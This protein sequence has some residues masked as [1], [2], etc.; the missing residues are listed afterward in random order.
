MRNVGWTRFAGTGM[1][2]PLMTF[3]R[4]GPLIEVRVK[5]AVKRGDFAEALYLLFMSETEYSREV[6]HY[7][8]HRMKL[9]RW[10]SSFLSATREL[11]LLA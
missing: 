8:Q 1:G 9:G 4:I 7:L 5:A 2:V 11:E 10:T 3:F 6:E